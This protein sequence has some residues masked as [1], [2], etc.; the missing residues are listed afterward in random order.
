MQKFMI[1]GKWILWLSF[2]I[3]ICA[4]RAIKGEDPTPTL[5]E[6]QIARGVLIDYFTHLQAG[7]YAEAAQL[8][9]G[10]YEMLTSFNPDVEADDY[11]TLWSNACQFNGLQCLLV[12]QAELIEEPIVG[13]FVF[14]VQFQNSEGSQFSLGP[15]CG[16]TE[17]ENPPQVDFNYTVVKTA[18]GDYMVM[19]LPVYVP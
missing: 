19:D 5:S 7:R 18:E 16:A 11:T 3:L 2:L 8:Y 10:T 1:I 4:C 9:G 17:A 6:P 12:R 15:C 14:R 13:K